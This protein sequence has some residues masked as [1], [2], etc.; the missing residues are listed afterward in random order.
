[1]ADQLQQLGS[2]LD[3][4]LQSVGRSPAEFEADLE[5][6]AQRAVK[7]G[8]VLDQ[9]A[10]Q[11]KLGVDAREMTAFVT[12]QARRMRVDPD[13]LARQLAD[14]GQLG[15]VASEVLRSKALDVIA[16]RAK[17]TD[18][19]GRDVD[20]QPP[21]D[22]DP[23]DQDAADEAAAA[24]GETDEASAAAGETDETDETA[25]QNQD[26]DQDQDQDAEAGAQAP[27]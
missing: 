11:E 24:T 26:Q 3:D 14:N 23:A 25:G 10:Q 18:E 22:Q 27:Q 8:F 15:S 9:L 19:A 12:E 1:M 6:D 2:S 13:Q 4:Y 21:A 16:Q 5:R 7:T 20:L 17:V